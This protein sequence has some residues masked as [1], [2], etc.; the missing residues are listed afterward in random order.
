[1]FHA[2]NLKLGILSCFLSEDSLAI[3]KLNELIEGLNVCRLKL[4][5]LMAA[6]SCDV[7]TEILFTIDQRFNDWLQECLMHSSN[8]IKIDHDLIEFEDL[9]REIKRN[10]FFVNALLPPAFRQMESLPEVASSPLSSG[11]SLKKQRTESRREEN[12]KPKPGNSLLVRNY[13]HSRPLPWATTLLESA[14]VGKC[15]NFVSVIANKVNTMSTITRNLNIASCVNSLRKL[16]TP[17]EEP[18]RDSTP[19]VVCHQN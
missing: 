18:G 10:K 14:S 9:I 7:L 1:M 6:K 19:A 12:S 11:P 5:M 15:A 4:E 17:N 3:H 8:I 16:G 2:L 13:R